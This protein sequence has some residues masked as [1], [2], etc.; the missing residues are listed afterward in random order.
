MN[1]GIAFI[2][3]GSRISLLFLFMWTYIVVIQFTFKE[4]NNTL[5]QTKPNEPSTKLDWRSYWRWDRVETLPCT[6]PTMVRQGI[7]ITLYSSN[8]SPSYMSNIELACNQVSRSML[9]DTRWWTW[10]WSL[11]RSHPTKVLV[12]CLILNWHV[13]RHPDP[14]RHGGLKVSPGI[15]TTWSSPNESP[16][17]MS[18]KKL[19]CN[20]ASY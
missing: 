2:N 20:Q 15:N 17:Y 16:L 13:S 7:N 11:P 10:V 9:T 8:E 5:D 3:L 12:T 19:T 4:R 6:C 1:A 14:G 18:N